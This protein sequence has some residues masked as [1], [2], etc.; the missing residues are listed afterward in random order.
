VKLKSVRSIS[1]GNLACK[2][3]GQVDDS[4][5]VERTFFNAHTTANTECFGNEANRGGGRD[6][7]TKFTNFVG[8]TSL[9]ALLVTLFGFALVRVDDGDSDFF[10]RG[11]RFIY[12]KFSKYKVLYLESALSG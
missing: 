12:H 8:R 1:V 10:I 2:S 5:C 6:L 7:D 9:R 4:D 3:L 11:L